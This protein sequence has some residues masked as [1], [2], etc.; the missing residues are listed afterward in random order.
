MINQNAGSLLL[1]DFPAKQKALFDIAYSR[2]ISDLSWTEI[3]D[4]EEA[5]ISLEEGFREYIDENIQI[6]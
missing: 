5:R 4:V 2:S 6:I 1:S 3:T